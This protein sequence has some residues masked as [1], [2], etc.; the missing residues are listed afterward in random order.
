MLNVL[1]GVA[2]FR[3]RG[4]QPSL[5]VLLFNLSVCDASAGLVNLYNFTFAILDHTFTVECLVRL[6]LLPYLHCGV[7]RQPCCVS[8]MY[9]L[10]IELMAV[11]MLSMVLL[12]LD[13]VLALVLGLRYD[14]LVNTRRLWMAIGFVWTLSAVFPVAGLTRV[15]MN[16]K[17]CI[18][19][20]ILPTNSFILY[21]SAC[22]L[23]IC[24]IVM[25]NLFTLKRT[26]GHIRRIARMSLGGQSRHRV[27][28]Q[29]AMNHKAIVTSVTVIIPFLVLNSPQYVL[30]LLFAFIPDWRESLYGL[31]AISIGVGL[32]LFNS[33]LNPII[34]VYRCTEVRHEVRRILYIFSIEKGSLMDTDISSMEKGSLMDTD[35]SSMEKGSLMEPD[36][37]SMEKGSLMEPDICSME[38]GSL[39]NRHLLHGEGVL[40]EQT[41]SPWRRDP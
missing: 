11:A 17:Y 25:L 5:R 3:A 7:S 38:K 1:V 23:I 33:L 16:S 12:S 21:G 6:V 29:V 35:T 24:F 9:G 2:L 41:S 18:F 36:T 20:I 10:V 37:S 40:N 34:F 31:I 22:L 13:R 28:R 32:V 39:M 8:Y 19:Q 26:F 15:D 27:V 4:L 14:A 30:F